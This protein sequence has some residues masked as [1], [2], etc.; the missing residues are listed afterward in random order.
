MPTRDQL[1]DEERSILSFV[2]ADLEKRGWNLALEM[3]RNPDIKL[4]DHRTVIDGYRHR[5]RWQQ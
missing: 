3:V 5:W 4:I 1:T 2:E